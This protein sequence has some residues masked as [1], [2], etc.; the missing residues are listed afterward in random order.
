MKRFA[1]ASL[2]VI[3]C[4]TPALAVDFPTRKAGL[5]QMNTT[6]ATGQ[7][8]SMQECV[9]AQT[10]QAMQS[11]FGGISQ[12]N[13]SKHDVQKSGDT[14]TID[15]VCTIAGHT[16]NGHVVVTGSFDS[17]YTMTMTSQTQGLPAPRTVTMT[18]KWVGPCAAGQRPGDMIMANGRTMNILDLERAVPGGFGG[19]TAPHQ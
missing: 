16:T 9:D 10:D 4:V 1:A 15:S 5:W 2:L 3:I 12:R 11:R 6:T 17:G 18:A 8:V 14:V 19:P 7:K 13:C